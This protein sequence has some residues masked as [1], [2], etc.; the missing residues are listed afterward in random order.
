M[1]IKPIKNEANYQNLLKRLDVIFYLWK[2]TEE[3]DEL[4]IP[5]IVMDN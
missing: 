1:N 5:S 2:E 3:R 4:E